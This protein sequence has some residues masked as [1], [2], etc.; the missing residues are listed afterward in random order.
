MRYEQSSLPFKHD[1][2]FNKVLCENTKTLCRMLRCSLKICDR[3]RASSVQTTTTMDA[4]HVRN[5]LQFP[6]VI[7]LI[8][9]SQKTDVE[10]IATFKLTQYFAYWV[11][12]IK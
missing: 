6:E 2:H 8:K 4:R 1:H 7:E 10:F 11:S 5:V 12:K 9:S 3:Y